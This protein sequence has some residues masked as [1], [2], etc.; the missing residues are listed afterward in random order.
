MDTLNSIWNY[1]GGKDK[2]VRQIGQKEPNQN[3]QPPRNEKF[4]L[5]DM[6]T[7]E[8]FEG[9]SEEIQ[10]REKLKRFLKNTGKITQQYALDQWNDSAFIDPNV[11]SEDEY[12]QKILLEKT[13]KSIEKN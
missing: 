10:Q 3:Y 1:F 2:Q 8:P 9:M 12:K 6:E 4:L 7:N 5:V 11:M 13:L